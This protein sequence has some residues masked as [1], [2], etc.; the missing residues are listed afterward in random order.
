MRSTCLR[1]LRSVL[2][3]LTRLE[4][5]RSRVKSALNSGDLAEY[6]KVLAAIDFSTLFDS[7]PPQSAVS[8]AQQTRKKPKTF[9]AADLIDVEQA[10]AFT[11]QIAQTWALLNG[12][13]VY[14]KAGSH[15]LVVS[16]SYSRCI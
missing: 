5:Y 15:F 16:Q 9:E 10:K 13:E 6:V 7:P 8:E 1:C 12:I 2:S 14:T 3:R 4:S 11:F